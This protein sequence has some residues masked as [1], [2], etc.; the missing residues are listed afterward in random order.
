MTTWGTVSDWRRSLLHGWLVGWLVLNSVRTQSRQ[1]CLQKHPLFVRVFRKSPHSSQSDSTKYGATGACCLVCFAHWNIQVVKVR[2]N[3]II[4]TGD[5]SQSSDD[6]CF[7]VR[8]FCIAFKA[9]SHSSVHFKCPQVFT[10][11]FVLRLYFLRTH[12]SVITSCIVWVLTTQMLT[13]SSFLTKR[14][15]YRLTYQWL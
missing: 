3:P 5:A 4:K 13:V 1:N 12:V 10:S 8:P 11:H 9:L 2:F 6:L 7:I 14:G 15:S